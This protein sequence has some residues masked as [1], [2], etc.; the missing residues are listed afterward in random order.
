[1]PGAPAALAPVPGHGHLPALVQ[2]IHEL[3]RLNPG[4]KN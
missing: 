3:C 1:M 4:G 2:L